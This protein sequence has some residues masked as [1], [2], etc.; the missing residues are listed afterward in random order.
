MWLENRRHTNER[1][2]KS[3]LKQKLTTPTSLD[4]GIKTDVAVVVVDHDKTRVPHFVCKHCK[5]N[6]HQQTKGTQTFLSSGI[7]MIWH[8]LHNYHV[9]CYFCLVM[10]VHGVN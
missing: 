9:D 7:P 5:E 2:D 6:H 4:N 8:E 1:N 3:E 10:I